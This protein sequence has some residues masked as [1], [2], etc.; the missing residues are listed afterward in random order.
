MSAR[1]YDSPGV[2]VHIEGP[3]RGEGCTSGPEGTRAFVFVEGHRGQNARSKALG[4]APKTRTGYCRPCL[5]ALDAEARNKV[6]AAA[7]KVARAAFASKQGPEAYLSKRAEGLVPNASR[8][9]RLAPKAEKAK[10]KA[11]AAP[12]QAPK[13]APKADAS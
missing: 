11:K 8:D 13:A 6:Q 1:T 3:C 10:A 12:K 9:K 2:G 5:S 7:E 4:R